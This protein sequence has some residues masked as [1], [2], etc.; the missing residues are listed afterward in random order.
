MQDFIT[1]KVI[2]I[3]L[4]VWELPCEDILLAVG[5][6]CPAVPSESTLMHYAGYLVHEICQI[7]LEHICVV[8]ELVDLAYH[9]D[10]VDFLARDHDLQV[11]IT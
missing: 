8:N 10:G 11:S 1:L 2:V 5:L 4:E 6:I 7:G 9:K 3:L